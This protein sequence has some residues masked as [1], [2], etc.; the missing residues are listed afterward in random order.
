MSLLFKM[1]GRN[2]P[3]GSAIAFGL[4]VV[5]AVWPNLGVVAAFAAEKVIE[6][7][8]QHRN[9]AV[10][11]TKVTLGS[12]EVQCGLVLSPAEIQPVTPIQAGDDWLQN[13]TIYLLNRTN[14]TIVEGQIVLVFPETGDGSP[15]NPL[16]VYNVTLGRLPASA[17][18][19]GRTGQAI[20]E[21]PSVQPISFAPSQTLQV[22]LSDYI[23]NIK[24]SIDNLAFSAVT[25]CV[26]RRGAFFFGDGMRWFAGSYYVPDPQ[27]PGKF[28]GLDG[29]YFPGTPTWPPGYHE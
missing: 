12:A 17:A 14:K 9:D 21:P 5:A 18:Y 28:T 26:I 16:R 10:A 23:D 6:V 20:V 4:L 1:R 29:R 11:I 13:V 7:E 3:R 27:H 24:A 19:S 2:G 8:P 25:K 22:H 15:G